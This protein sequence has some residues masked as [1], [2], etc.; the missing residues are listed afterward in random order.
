MSDPDAT[1]MTVPAL[2]DAFAQTV[3][4]VIALGRSCSPADFE[5][6]TDCPG[7]TVHDQIAH[8]AGVESFLHGEPQ[9]VVEVPDYAYLRHDIGRFIEAGVEARRGVPGPAVVDELAALLPKRLAVLRDPALTARTPLR[10]L[11]G[12]RPAEGVL[13]IRVTDVWV[14]EQDLREALGLP[15]GMDTAAAAVF[16]GL[17][18]DSA[19]R[20]ISRG[21]AVPAGQTVTIEV[22]GPVTASTSVAVVT[23]ED[24]KPRGDVVARP[25]AGSPGTTL[26]SLSARDLTRRGAGR[27]AREAT[28]YTVVGDEAVAARVLDELAVTP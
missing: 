14:H 5:L 1:A 23:A 10:G 16:V 13:R 27:I 21:A 24:G 22:T 2:V 25:A 19:P 4:A 3:G 7:W 17:V 26:I 28:T 15:G 8:V 9:P 20:I 18:L 6:P 11:L 12:E